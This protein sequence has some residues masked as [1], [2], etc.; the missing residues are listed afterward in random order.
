MPLELS[1]L[2]WPG[3]QQLVSTD[4]T[5]PTITNTGI[6]TTTIT[7]PYLPPILGLM[8]HAQAFVLY[9]PTGVAVSNGLTGVVGC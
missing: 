4:T 5:T 3:C 8:F 7:L 9:H 2:G 1:A 6:A